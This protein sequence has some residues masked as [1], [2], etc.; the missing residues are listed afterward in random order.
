MRRAAA[1]PVIGLA[2]VVAGPACGKRPSALEQAS[3]QLDSGGSPTPPPPPAAGA[4]EP[5]SKPKPKLNSGPAVAPPTRSSPTSVTTGHHS[6]DISTSPG[7]P[8]GVVVLWPRVIPR[9]SVAP[10][11]AVRA[12]RHMVDLVRATLPGRPLDIRPS[13][14]RT[15]RRAGCEATSIGVLLSAR[16]NGCVAIA[17]IIPPGPVE[18]TLV[19]WGGKVSLDTT[20]IPFREPP[21]SRVRVTDFASCD[22]L[23]TVMGPN[24]E[25]VANALRAAAPPPP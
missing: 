17:V 20:Q 25:S 16:N 7:E 23:L 24:D 22:Q 6:A 11:L 8:G 4:P 19:P 1:A 3:A 5:E 10:S 2:M 13:P 9:G 15:C 12:Q 14:Q 21:E 18:T